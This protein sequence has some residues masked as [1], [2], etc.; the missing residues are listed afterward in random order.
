M[1]VEWLSEKIDDFIIHN[2]NVLK[3]FS[4]LLIIIFFV[5]CV[6]FLIAGIWVQ[7]MKNGPKKLHSVRKHSAFANAYISEFKSIHDNQV[8]RLSRSRHSRVSK[9]VNHDVARYSPNNIIHNVAKPTVQSENKKK[10]T[11]LEFYFEFED[12]YDVLEE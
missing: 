7:L 2:Q 6:A 9:R 11:T 3:N 8:S 10:N 4:T 1:I 12:N 5:F